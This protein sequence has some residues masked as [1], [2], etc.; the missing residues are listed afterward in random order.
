MVNVFIQFCKSC[1]W[2]HLVLNLGGFK[3]NLFLKANEAC[4]TLQFSTEMC[5]IL[6]EIL[7]FPKVG[8]VIL[9]ANVTGLKQISP[10]AN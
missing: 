9:F 1:P 3:F 6:D 4:C 8:F 5:T 10:V 7:K 2:K